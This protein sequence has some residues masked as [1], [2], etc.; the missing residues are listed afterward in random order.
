MGRPM[1]GH[2]LAAGHTLF[3]HNRSTPAPALIEAG[4]I[5]C[6]TASD[7]AACADIII[8]MLPDT[9]DVASVL[10]GTGGVADALTPA[11]P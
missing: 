8:T 7:V 11:R 9:D 1:A 10:F 6:G 4:A 2:L 5:A 3:V